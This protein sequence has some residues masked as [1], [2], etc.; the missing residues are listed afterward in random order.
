MYFSRVCVRVRVGFLFGSGLMAYYYD[1]EE[2]A[3]VLTVGE[4]EHGGGNAG[5]DKKKRGFSF[6]DLFDSLETF[7]Y[8]L[9]LMLML[10]VFVF[11][12]VTVNGTSMLDTLQ[13]EDRLIISDVLYTPKTGD[14]VVLD[15]TGY[16]SDKYIIKRVIATGGQA[17]EID[18]FDWTVTVD[19]Q[20]LDEGYIRRE[21]GHMLSLGWIQLDDAVE[22]YYEDGALRTASFT[23][24]DNMLFVMGDNRNG[25]SDSRAVGFFDED[26]I[27]GRVLLRLDFDKFGRVE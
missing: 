6:K 18:F 7:C 20:R 19:G 15:A 23:V 24:P 13:H 3:G 16:F 27:L 8:A 26:R 14:I 5:G 10:F 2:N 11:R 17:V 22:R 21:G 25:S 12:F 1:N 9:V 4:E